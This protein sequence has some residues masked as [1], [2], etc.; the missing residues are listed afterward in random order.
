MAD[1]PHGTSIGARSEAVT[2]LRR[3]ID[4][5]RHR[6]DSGRFVVDG[7]VLVAEALTS[8]CAVGCVFVDVEAID[9]S[10]WPALAQAAETA[11]V[12]VVTVAHG[13]LARVLDPVTPR[14]VCA[15]VERPTP[16][17]PDALSTAERV[18]VL[19]GVGDPG[20]VGTL[21]RTAEAAAFDAVVVCGEAADPFGPKAVRASAGSILRVAVVVAP[22]GGGLVGMLADAGSTVI[23]TSTTGA[24]FRSADLGERSVVIVG[25]EAHG[26]SGDLGSRVAQWVAIP[27]EGAVES[28]NAAVAG[29]LLAFEVAR[30]HSPVSSESPAD[31]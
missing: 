27:M 12:A 6:E 28:L 16:P 25:S 26:V 18:L 21:V 7:P 9:R 30:R 5:R 20:N 14:P 22:D 31:R 15:V 1:R 29:S 2:D 11:G 23:G 19:D 8:P 4:R 17:E 3:L 24:D 10:W 13:V